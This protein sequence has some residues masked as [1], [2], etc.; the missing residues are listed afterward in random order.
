MTSDN[1][2]LLRPVL[3]EVTDRISDGLELLR[4]LIRDLD[5]ELLYEGH[6]PLDRVQRIRAEVSDERCLPRHLLGLHAELVDDDLAN[7]RIDVVRHDALTVR[8][9]HDHSA[10]HNDD[11]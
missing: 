11:L 6:D 10:I 9:S 5:P 4:L 1:P 2:A 3:L 7:L 8:A